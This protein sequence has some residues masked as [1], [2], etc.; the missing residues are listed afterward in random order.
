MT[1]NE[2]LIAKLK[3][4]VLERCQDRIIDAKNNKIDK[5]MNCEEHSISSKTKKS[6]GL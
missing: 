1:N 5:I 4:N 3:R 2:E 6:R